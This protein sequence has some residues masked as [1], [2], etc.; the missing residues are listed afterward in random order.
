MTTAEEIANRA[1]F[2][3]S[4]KSSPITRPLIHLDGGY[5]HLDRSLG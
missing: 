4:E 5:V 3:L 2:L 1:A